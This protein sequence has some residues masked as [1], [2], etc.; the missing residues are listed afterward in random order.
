[1]IPQVCKNLIALIIF[2]FISISFTYAQKNYTLN[3]IVKS[4]ISGENLIGASVKISGP[5]TLATS[6]NA[7][8]FYAV[9][10]PKGNYKIEISYIGYS[11]CLLY[12]SRCV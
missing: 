4:A 12:T 5:T 2:Y 1:M 6:T 3:G 7:Y 8:G 11:T 10:L 9:T